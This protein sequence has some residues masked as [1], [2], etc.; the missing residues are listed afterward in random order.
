MKKRCKRRVIVPLPPP[1]MRPKLRGDQVLDLSLVHAMNLDTIARGEAG[2]ALLWDWAGSVLTWSKAAELS[3]AGIDEMTAQL[4]LSNRLIE[5][6]RHTGKVRFTGPD[7]QLAKDGLQVMDQLAQLVDK[8]VAI[9]AANWSEARL[10]ELSSS[11]EH[12]ECA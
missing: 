1:G 3:G 5:R 12:R 6:Y 7:Y 11:I 4:E 8:H 10:N 2:E 9:K